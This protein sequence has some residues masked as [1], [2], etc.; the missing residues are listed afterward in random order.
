MQELSRLQ[1]LEQIGLNHFST[2]LFYAA[3]LGLSHNVIS[4]LLDSGQNLS[5][6]WS[7]SGEKL[8]KTIHDQD[9][10]TRGPLHAAAAR[11]YK[12][13][14]ECLLP[15]ADTIDL[16][17]DRGKTPLY[18]AI[19]GH[20]RDIVYYL[21]EK[22]ADV[23]NCGPFQYTVSPIQQAVQWGNLAIVEF[24]LDHGAS[25]VHPHVDNP[26]KKVMA[27]VLPLVYLATSCNH[28]SI[29]KTLLEH[30][31]DPNEQFRPARSALAIAC[32][33]GNRPLFDLLL[34]HE[35]DVNGKDDFF[36]NPLAAACD[37]GDEEMANILLDHGALDSND[38]GLFCV[39]GLV[40]AG[41]RGKHSLV[42]RLLETHPPEYRSSERLN[43]ALFAA[44]GEGHLEIVDLVLAAGADVNGLADLESREVNQPYDTVL[45]LAAAKGQPHIVQALIDKGADA[46]YRS[47]ATGTALDCARQ[48]RQEAWE[49]QIQ[50]SLDE[51]ITCL[52]AQG[53]LDSSPS[54]SRPYQ[55]SW[56]KSWVAK[57]VGYAM[58][59]N[60]PEPL[61][62]VFIRAFARAVSNGGTD[63]E[64][65][66]LTRVF[67]RL[68]LA[69]LGFTGRIEAALLELTD[70]AARHKSTY[71][72][73]EPVF[74]SE[75][76][77]KLLAPQEDVSELFANTLSMDSEIRALQRGQEVE[78]DSIVGHSAPLVRFLNGL[79]RLEDSPVTAES[80]HAII[81][82]L[83]SMGIVMTVHGKLTI[84][85]SKF[86]P[87]AERFGASRKG[88]EI[89][90]SAIDIRLFDTLLEG[91]KEASSPRVLD[92][93]R[94]G[95]RGMLTRNWFM[96]RTHQ[97]MLR[98]W[99]IGLFMA[100]M[101]LFVKS[102]YSSFYS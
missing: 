40:S 74:F 92:S 80:V 9:L 27:G 28:F 95:V 60:I 16:F 35:A 55:N 48:A 64:D 47:S 38:G 59:R 68:V 96:I 15:S 61:R 66:D 97:K 76:A 49:E 79:L 31:A 14:V 67:F 45:Q 72:L 101:A 23:N 41:R 4:S 91:P 94:T 22:G 71:D 88:V 36:C 81:L 93:N 30:E 90:A 24:L 50:I 39:S 29:V 1:D 82:R 13:V 46:S 2:P 87:L 19:S 34:Q 18:A 43:I 10:R 37:I 78:L 20:Q 8:L 86:M 51:V 85:L 44:A 65:E 77:M 32:R 102:L 7:T 70:R 6:C 26:S 58:F 12:E 84:D 63:L 89:V 42:H 62:D 11:G 83:E 53:A 33:N 99:L 52:Q 75:A 56:F 17:D 69:E 73:D 25:L 98:L 100:M 54:D 3:C 5:Y 57:T 21:V